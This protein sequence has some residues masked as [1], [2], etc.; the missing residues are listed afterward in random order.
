[1]VAR[2]PGMKRLP[3]CLLGLAVAAAAYVLPGSAIV[4]RMVE[5]RDEL[6]LGSARV[7]GTLS[8]SGGAM[9]ELGTELPEYRTDA[10]FSLR[11]PGRCR[12]DATAPGGKPLSVVD[13]S[14]RRRTEGAAVA[15]LT[16]AVEEVCALLALRA[17]S[18]L[19]AHLRTLRVDTRETSL[20]RLGG[21]VAYVLGGQK[22][23][24]G[25]LW[26]FKESFFPAR[27]RWTDEHGQTWD[28]RFVDFGSPATGAWF[29]RVVEV[30]RGGELQARFT[31]LKG[32]SHA[33]FPDR[34][35]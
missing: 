32:D 4:R 26:V 34:F 16:T 33:T 5:G 19:E 10:T 8:L 28:V 7:D 17:S 27:I 14:G 18:D 35:F 23:A 20:G 15:A 3:L 25:Q 13:A 22:P 24:D 2:S 29:P 12:L 21:Q 9:A 31:A 6:H 11:V 30:S 1:M